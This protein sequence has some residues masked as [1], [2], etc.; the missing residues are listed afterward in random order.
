M[1]KKKSDESRRQF[2]ALPYRRTPDGGLEVMLVTSRETRRW[3]IPKG[4][5]MK[6]LAPYA[7]AAREA[8]EEAG[9]AGSIAREPLGS[10]TYEKRLKSRDYVSCEVEVFAM[11]VTKEAKRWP[12]RDERERRWFEPEAAARRVEEEELAE[13]IL[14][15][16][17]HLAEQIEGPDESFQ[18]ESWNLSR[19][20]T[21]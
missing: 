9:L 14:D 21:A 8:Y 13:I 16:P 6:K 18:S 10:F 15:L 2:G 12:E 1:K 20:A 4:W 7:A 5:P 19:R 11:E 3:V 17:R